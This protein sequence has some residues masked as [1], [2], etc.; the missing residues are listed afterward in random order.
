MGDDMIGFH[1]AA[2]AAAT[3]VLARGA[4]SARA[5]FTGTTETCGA[6]ECT[7]KCSP[8][9]DLKVDH[10]GKIR[11][12]FNGGAPFRIVVYSTKSSG[13]TTPIAIYERQCV[14]Q[15]FNP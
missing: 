2:L 13:Y 4:S 11:I 5:D 6:S 9:V 15:G 7:V 8:D 12:E 14:T 1:R 3:A 10:G